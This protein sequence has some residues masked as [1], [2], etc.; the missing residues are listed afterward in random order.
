MKDYRL[1]GWL[2]LS[3]SGKQLAAVIFPVAATQDSLP[4]LHLLDL[5]GHPGALIA[6][7]QSLVD[8]FSVAFSPSGQYVGYMLGI[9][10]TVEIF[11]ISTGQH[12]PV[13]HGAEAPALSWLGWV[14]PGR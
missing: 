1:F 3:P 4:E 14:R 2:W 12:I 8:N 7:S 6:K 11:D 13:Y 9:E 5:N 10:Q